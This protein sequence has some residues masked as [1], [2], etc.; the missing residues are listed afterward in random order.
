VE[1]LVERFRR[2]RR[3]LVERLEGLGEDDL[4]RAALH[5]RLELPMTVVD[6]CF[7]VAE[8]D[9]HHLATITALRSAR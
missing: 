7:F 9:D 4:R 2:L 3:R 6:H 8:H 5:P 1:E